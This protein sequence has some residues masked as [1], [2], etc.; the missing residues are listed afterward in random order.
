MSL[1][2]CRCMVENIDR[3]MR[4]LNNEIEILVQIADY[5]PD[6][7]HVMTNASRQK[8]D[9]FYMEYD[10]FFRFAKTLETLAIS[11]S[12]NKAKAQNRQSN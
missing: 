7:H 2:E 6:F 1:T 12:E 5:M 9:A 4:Q 3:K 8:M 11:I 10:G